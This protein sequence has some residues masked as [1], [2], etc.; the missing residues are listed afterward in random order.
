MSARFHVHLCAVATRTQVSY[1]LAHVSI[2]L[3]D[4]EEE[5]MELEIQHPEEEKVDFAV[6]YGGKIAL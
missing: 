6:L 4:R 3:T 5:L 2:R 1:S